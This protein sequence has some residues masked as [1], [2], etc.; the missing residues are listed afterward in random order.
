M[1]ELVR[2]ESHTQVALRPPGDHAVDRVRAHNGFMERPN[3]LEIIARC[4]RLG[5]EAPTDDTTYYVGRMRIMPTGPAPMMR[6]RKRL[7]GFMARH[8]TSV[9]DFFSIPADQVVELGARIEF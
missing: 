7:F 8:A 5:L 6:W 3:V 9:P 2:G 4:R 1:A